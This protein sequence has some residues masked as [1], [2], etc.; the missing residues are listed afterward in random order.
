MELN[1]AT[2]CNQEGFSHA[3]GQRVIGHGSFDGFSSHFGLEIPVA[4]YR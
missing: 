3:L 1:M 4:R 2:W